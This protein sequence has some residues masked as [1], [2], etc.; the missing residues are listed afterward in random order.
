MFM[1]SHVIS[2]QVLFHRYPVEALRVATLNLVPN[3]ASL[4]ASISK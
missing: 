1:L 3:T 4:G 2:L